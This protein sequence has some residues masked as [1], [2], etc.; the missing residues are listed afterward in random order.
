[1]VLRF[2][3]L[4]KDRAADD[5]S[6]S[7]RADECRR[8]QCSLPLATDVVGLPGE[9]AGDVGIASGRGNEH[10]KVTNTNILDI[11]KEWKTWTIVRKQ[12]QCRVDT[13]QS[14]AGIR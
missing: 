10:A 8:A 4:A 3:L 14:A 11:A 2:V 7:S 12:T 1:M 6:D 13:Y 9:D 5:A